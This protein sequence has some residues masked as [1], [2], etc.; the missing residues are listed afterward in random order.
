MLFVRGDGVILIS[1]PLRTARGA[2]IRRVD[3]DGIE[4]SCGGERLIMRPMP[5]SGPRHPIVTLQFIL[6]S[7]Q[8]FLAAIHGH[9]IRLF[10]KLQASTHLCSLGRDSILTRGVQEREPGDAILCPR[11]ATPLDPS[12]RRLS[13]SAS[14][15][16]LRRAASVACEPP[17]ARAPPYRGRTATF[18]RD[19]AAR[20]A[21]IDDN[22]AD[23]PPEDP[24]RAM[25][26]AKAFRTNSRHW[27]LFIPSR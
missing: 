8:P 2:R 16:V 27:S 19:K 9:H 21:L 14:L 15:D 22:R 3:L 4:T 23:A 6:Y 1:P 17:A 5:P 18:A 20:P 11:Y 10:E 12:L 24:S 7:K 25:A 13:R 26:C